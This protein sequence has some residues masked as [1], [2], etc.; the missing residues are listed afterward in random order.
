MWRP[1]LGPFAL[2]TQPTAL[3]LYFSFIFPLPGLVPSQFSL[4]GRGCGVWPGLKEPT[5]WQ[6]ACDKGN[7]ITSVF[8]CLP[9]LAVGCTWSYEQ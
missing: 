4:L 5:Q 7:D 3:L 8:P 6:C 1:L 2:L 9:D